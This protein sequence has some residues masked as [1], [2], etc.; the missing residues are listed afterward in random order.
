VSNEVRGRVVGVLGK[1]VASREA[2]TSAEGRMPVP[3]QA[4]LPTY[5]AKYDYLS[6]EHL[7]IIEN[8]MINYND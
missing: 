1:G 4:P 6:S 5:L 3:D 8:K 2:V 7:Q